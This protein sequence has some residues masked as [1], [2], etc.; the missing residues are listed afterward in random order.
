MYIQFYNIFSKDVSIDS[1]K[2]KKKYKKISHRLRN[3]RRKL[4]ESSR[5]IE[6]E[7]DS[8]MFLFSHRPRPLNT[9]VRECKFE[10]R[11]LKMLHANDAR[12]APRRLEFQMHV[13]CDTRWP[14]PS[15][16]WSV[17]IVKRRGIRGRAPMEAFSA[18]VWSM[19]TALQ[20]HV[21]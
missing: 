16:R 12:D 8:R 14:A 3:H 21:L 15:R 7:R 10:S 13:L 9:Y 1:S 11:L 4:L 17:V 18:V 19:W 20:P 6:S 2:F 5:T